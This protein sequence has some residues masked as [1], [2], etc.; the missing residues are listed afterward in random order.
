MDIGT[1]EQTNRSREH[2]IQKLSPLTNKEKEILREF[3]RCFLYRTLHAGHGTKDCPDCDIIIIQKPRERADGRGPKHLS[4]GHNSDE[5]SDIWRPEGQPKMV[6]MTG[7]RSDNKWVYR[8]SGMYH[9]E[10]CKCSE[11]QDRDGEEEDEFANSPNRRQTERPIQTGVK[12]R[13]PGPR[14]VEREEELTEQQ[15]AEIESAFAAR[16]AEK[17]EETE[18]KKEETEETTCG[19]LLHKLREVKADPTLGRSLSEAKGRGGS[20]SVSDCV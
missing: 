8:P 14:R 17:E 16:Q 20:K 2:N 12:S 11:G 5:T 7:E 10:G 9:I 15:I 19:A 6:R 18:S 3:H 4:F 13:M 1:L